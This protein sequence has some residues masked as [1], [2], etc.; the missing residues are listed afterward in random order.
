MSKRIERKPIY[1]A[2]SVAT[3]ATS[4]SFPLGKGVSLDELGA[5]GFF[6]AEITITGTGT[7][8]IG[9]EV[10]SDGDTW[11]KGS[12]QAAISTALTVA[13]A[14]TA[15]AGPDSD[16]KYLIQLININTAKYIRFYITETGGAAAV[17]VTMNLIAQ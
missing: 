8:T 17:V 13:T 14:L 16:G 5:E 4:A 12:T 10:S 9:Y 11:F 15:A 2:F 7:A 3:S 1:N 6:S